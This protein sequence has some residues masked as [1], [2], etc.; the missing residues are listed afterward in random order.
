MEDLTG[1]YRVGVIPHLEKLRDCIPS[2]GRG[3]PAAIE[4]ARA[5]SHQLKGS[6]TSFGHPEITTLANVVLHASDADLVQ[7][8]EALV[9]GLDNVVGANRAVRRIAVV[10]DDPLIRMIVTRTLSRP[11]REFL[12]AASIGVARTVIDGTID[13]VVL[14][15]LLPD[16]NGRELLEV[17]KADPSTSGI[18]VVVLSGSGSDE[19]RDQVMRAGAFACVEKPFD[20]DSFSALID[21]VL[22]VDEARAAA[23]NQVAGDPPPADHDARATVLV[24]EDDEL[25]AALIRDRLQRDG[26]EIREHRDG[27]SALADALASP[28]DLVILDVMMPRMN[29]FEV[30]GRLRESSKTAEMPVILLTG[31]GREEDVVR[32]FALGASDYIIKPFSPAELAVRVRR[33][34]TAS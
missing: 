24:A 4:I 20:A 11:G 10:D 13:L 5:I 26:Y 18:P 9:A 31:R 27:E 17:L 32:G 12:E 6:G 2:A 28:P 3:D 16:G 19:L 1:A 34:T 15:F 23:P 30:L 25:V 33:H 8:A 14:D 22:G 29:G 21:Q 7:A